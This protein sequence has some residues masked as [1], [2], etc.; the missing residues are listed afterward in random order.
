M[1]TYLFVGN[2]EEL[3]KKINFNPQSLFLYESILIS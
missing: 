3:E 2:L 1:Y